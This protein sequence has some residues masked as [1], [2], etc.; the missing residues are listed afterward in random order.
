MGTRRIKG[1]GTADQWMA[2]GAKL[3]RARL[4]IM[5]VAQASLGSRRLKGRIDT[6]LRTL[7]AARNRCDG[8][9]LDSG[10][11]E[12][13]EESALR[14][15]YGEHENDQRPEAAGVDTD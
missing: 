4:L 14:V 8:E 1:S 13:A 2:A 10:H 5:E 7:D 11:P 6:A 12:A 9:W 15:F 3:K